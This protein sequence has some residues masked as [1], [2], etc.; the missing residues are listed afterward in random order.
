V[1]GEP[2]TTDPEVAA[3]TFAQHLQQ[4]FASGR[5]AGPGWGRKDLDPLTCVVRVPAVR[6]DGTKDHYF[7]RLGAEYYPTWPPRTAFVTPL[8]G[9][10]YE[11]AADGTRWWPR[12]NN[13]PGFAF[14]LHPSYRYPD[15]HHEPLICFSHTFE[16][17]ISSHSPSESERWDPARHTLAATL[18]RIAA[19]LTAPNYEGPS[20]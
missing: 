19:V 10:T 12:Q 6:A 2:V 3:A 18:N 17:Y 13:Q 4:F 20:G 16:Y 9:G 8:D 14:G 5:G 11:L 15:G 7:V 1:S